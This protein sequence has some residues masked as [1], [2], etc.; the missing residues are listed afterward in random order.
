[1]KI[2]PVNASL[3]F[4]GSNSAYKNE[5]E[6]KSDKTAK[7]AIGTAVAGAGLLAVYFLTRNPK[8]A[9]KETKEIK[10]Q[11]TQ[12]AE[13]V[14]EEAVKEIKKLKNGHTMTKITGEDSYGNEI[15]E[16]VFKDENN[17]IYKTIKSINKLE[18]SAGL[19]VGYEKTIT[20]STPNAIPKTIINTYALDMRA[21]STTCSDGK[22]LTYCYGKRTGNK[23]IGLAYTEDNKIKLKF[24]NK[25]NIVKEFSDVKSMYKWANGNII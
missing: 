15:A 19:P 11:T 5:I 21:K 24:N 1:M 4:N 17:K 2:L 18:T 12:I 9:S 22:T 3:Y 16:R 8:G 6:Q 25:P 13:Q 10:E 7:L 14:I 20:I 23:I